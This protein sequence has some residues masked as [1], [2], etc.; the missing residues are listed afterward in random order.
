MGEQRLDSVHSLVLLD[1]GD[2]YS[3]GSNDN[4]QCG[5]SDQKVLRKPVLIKGLPRL[6]TVIC[7]VSTSY[8]LD[9]EVIYFKVEVRE[10]YGDG[11]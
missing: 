2:V 3:L 7:S 6:L 11:G 1:S 5:V 8:G 9:S 4:G 10:I